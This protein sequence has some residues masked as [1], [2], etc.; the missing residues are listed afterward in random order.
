M[1]WISGSKMSATRKLVKQLKDAAKRKRAAADLLKMGADAAPALIEALQTEDQS[2]LPVYGQIL[3]R[4]GPLT[5]PALTYSLQNDHPIIRGRIAEILAQTKD[6][7]AIPALLE[8]LRGEFYTVRSR[9]ASALGAIGDQ[10]S[11][12]PLIKALNDEEPEV[13]IEAVTAIGK[14]IIPETFDNMADPLLEDTEIEVRQ[15]AAKALGGTQ[16]PQAIPY[17]MLALRDPYWWY[18]REQAAKELL[19]T[20]ESMGAMVVDPLLEALKDSEGT[21][22]RYAATMLGHIGDT[23]AIDPLGMALYDTHFEV[24]QV[25]AEALAGFGEPGLKVLAEALQHPEAWLRQHAI[26]GLI[27]SGDKRIVPAIL[28]MLND[29][30]REV[31][32][33]AVQSLGEL[34]D[35]R[36]LPALQAIAANRADR[37]MHTL[38]R[39]AIENLNS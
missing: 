32:K 27:L 1:N 8:A 12:Q 2:L 11:V 14:F 38:A 34:K 28:E 13:R 10:G 31:Q 20:I 5:T 33:Q 7:Q 24:G 18:E 19:K 16:R 6:P 15:A 21:V 3:V 23:R 4:M 22:R 37:E 29:P 26:T 30:E 39:Q 9:A 35:E 25:A 36:A 17:L